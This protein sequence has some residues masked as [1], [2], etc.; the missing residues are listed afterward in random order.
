MSYR[1]IQ[2]NRKDQEKTYS[3]YLKEISADDGFESSANEE[4]IKK[5]EELFSYFFKK[6][7]FLDSFLAK[8]QIGPDFLSA[9]IYP[10][11]YDEFSN[12]IKSE[13][14][15]KANKNTIYETVIKRDYDLMDFDRFALNVLN[16]I[17]TPFAGKE[18]KEYNTNELVNEIITYLKNK[19]K[20][21]Y[22]NFSIQ[23]S[24]KCE[25]KEIHVYNFNELIGKK[26]NKEKSFDIKSYDLDYVLS[27]LYPIFDM[28]A[29]AKYS[30]CGEK[31]KQII[32]LN[33]K[34]LLY[35][36]NIQ[37]DEVEENIEKLF[38]EM[39]KNKEIQP[40]IDK[41]RLYKIALYRF[42]QAIKYGE[43]VLDDE[44]SINKFLTI[45]P[46]VQ[47][48]IE[49]IKD[50]DK[51]E[52]PIV[53]K[54]DEA[55]NII[56]ATAKDILEDYN[57]TYTNFLNKCIS[58]DENFAYYILKNSNP[59][60]INVDFEYM[61]KKVKSKGNFLYLGYAKKGII[62]KEKMLE[63]LDGLDFEQQNLIANK[64][65]MNNDKNLN[66][67]IE[68]EFITGID[69]RKLYEEGTISTKRIKEVFAITDKPE[70][71]EGLDFSSTKLVELYK[72]LYGKDILSILKQEKVRRNEPYSEEDIQKIIEEN[73]LLNLE[74]K[75]VDEIKKLKEEFRFQKDM[76]KEF[77]TEDDI[78]EF[79]VALGNDLEKNP[80]ITLDLLN[81][82]IITEEQAEIMSNGDFINRFIKNKND[83]R[84]INT[85]TSK[86]V[87]AHKNKLLNL[88]SHK[89]ISPDEIIKLYAKGI[90]PEDL[91]RELDKS[92]F[93]GKV[94][95]KYLADFAE[96]L[97][98]SGKYT[99]YGELERYITEC[100]KYAETDDFFKLY[101][102]KIINSKKI[103]NKQL[104]EL[105]KRGLL[106]K[107]ALVEILKR[108]DAVV[109]ANLIK[110]ENAIDVET[111]RELFLDL[112][113]S[114]NTHEKRDL[115]EKVIKVG[116]LSSEEVLAILMETYSIIETVSDKQKQL[117]N[118]NLQYFFDKVMVEI[119]ERE[120]RGNQTGIGNG[121][122]KDSNVVSSIIEENTQRRF[123]LT[124]RYGCI[125]S[126]DKNSTVNVKGP[127]LVFNVKK[128]DK[129]V[130]ETLGTMKDEVLQ[131]DLTNHRT[132]I[133]D[134]NTYE[135]YKCEFTVLEDEKEIIQFGKLYKWYKENKDLLH[136]NE[137]IHKEHWEENIRKKITKNTN[138]TD[139]NVIEGQLNNP[140]DKTH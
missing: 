82:R 21:N 124:E 90:I 70:I 136:L 55:Y 46:K 75:S 97:K 109:I 89:R 112:C 92:G 140:N 129:T 30:V 108:G 24:E 49:K 15:N 14:F 28:P 52:L 91:Y 53:D 32:L 44:K 101:D 8:P 118:E 87:V 73:N 47:K 114:D 11:S 110:G 20:E 31:I 43:I 134:K 27:Y 103:D 72:K 17:N 96:K 122:K 4:S 45:M 107:T 69:L 86:E 23:Q 81:K 71:K 50:S 13:Y 2:I 42:T 64:L 5:N 123:P 119:I 39:L 135:Q 1:T 19:G 137:C 33:T 48:E 58:E 22:I 37:K 78:F 7:P 130:I 115:F 95:S 63:L 79:L 102:D 18:L 25:L 125:L 10:D 88:I 85:L 57:E 66:F 131:N 26:S 76:F 77:A 38:I 9:I 100:K 34:K 111:A 105:G 128:Y 104:I 68:N 120:V 126:L 138:S 133:M 65:I 51:E 29:I 35:A 93:K 3:K 127:A 62:S 61:M 12:R 56:F 99:D 41:Y 36:E 60:L 106:S 113:N 132:Y 40:Y 121:N 98:I 83:R 16:I 6:Y 117:N 67:F 84:Y 80:Y 139:E 54:T 94:D 59:Q 74:N 116:K